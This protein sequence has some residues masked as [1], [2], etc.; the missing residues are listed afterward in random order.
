MGLPGTGPG[1]LDRSRC[2]KG[3][4]TFFVGKS[5]KQLEN[6]LKVTL[7]DLKETNTMFCVFFSLA[8][9]EPHVCIRGA[10]CL[11]IC[12]WLQAIWSY[13]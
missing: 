6:N 13:K 1:L 9:M 10:H 3:L 4:I 5:T 8:L 12:L 11:I 2:M 7:I